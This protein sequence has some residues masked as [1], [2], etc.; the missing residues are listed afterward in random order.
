MI[1]RTDDGDRLLNIAAALTV[2]NV[3]I[4]NWGSSVAY[5]T[6][7]GTV[8]GRGFERIPDYMSSFG[9]DMAS[10]S[11]RQGIEAL[12]ERLS[13]VSLERVSAR[14]RDQNPELF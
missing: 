7:S 6:P 13:A 9:A 8:L 14:P 5:N 11:F 12:P 1:R 2:R 4:G 10:T 3:V